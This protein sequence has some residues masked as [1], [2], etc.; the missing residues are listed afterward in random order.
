M[1]KNSP[2]PFVVSTFRKSRKISP[3]ILGKLKG[4]IQARVQK[5]GPERFCAQNA[6]PNLLK[7]V[8]PVR[9]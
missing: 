7:A 8:F 3:A 1:A 2:D 4:V 5:V 9:P 6:W